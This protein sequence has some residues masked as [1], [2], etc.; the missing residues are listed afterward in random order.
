[1][2]RIHLWGR[3]FTIYISVK[4]VIIITLPVLNVIFH[5]TNHYTS[6]TYRATGEI[7]PLKSPVSTPLYNINRQDYRK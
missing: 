5:K 1:M 2:R 4:N 7:K 3:G 6:F